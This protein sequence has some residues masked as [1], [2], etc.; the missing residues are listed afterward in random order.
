MVRVVFLHPDLGIGGAE[1]LV[2]DA[3]LALRSRGHDVLV[4]TAHHDPSHC[5]PETIDGTLS[6]RAAGDWLPSSLLGSCRALCA[7]VR[8]LYIALYLL[9]L[10]SFDVIFCDQISACIPLLKLFSRRRIVFYCHFPDQLLTRRE[11]FLKR[12]YRAPLDWLEEWSTGLAH[13]ILVNSMFT[14]NVF[15]DTFKS[16]SK[17]TPQVLYPSLNFSAFD[18]ETELLNDDVL[19]P[20]RDIYFLSINRYERKK[21]LA[22]AIEAFSLLKLRLSDEKWRRTHLVMAGGYDSRVPENRE[23]HD[24]LR[25]LV[26]SLNLEEHVTFLRSVSDARK[27]ALLRGCA[28]LVYTPSGE[29]FGIVPVEA[30]YAGRPVVAVAS[31][32]PLETVVDASTGFLRKADAAAFA[33]AMLEFVDDETLGSAMGRRGR[34]LVLRRFSFQAFTE[35]LDNV[36]TAR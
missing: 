5:F 1:R 2:I 18:T 19:P 27:R 26:A 24:E 33:D 31:G 13:V 22:L 21:N 28:C 23:H 35:Q 34:E 12:V 9:L 6:V 8:M 30:M 7:Y 16:L 10:E 32:G 29:H 4:I 36:V 3:A 15:K 17:V 25:H 11:S 20:G 14:A